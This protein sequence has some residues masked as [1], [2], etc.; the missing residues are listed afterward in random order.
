MVLGGHGNVYQVLDYPVD[1][2]VPAT[3][4]LPILRSGGDHT[5]DLLFAMPVVYI[6]KLAI[7]PDQQTLRDLHLSQL[8]HMNLNS[9]LKTFNEAFLRQQTMAQLTI[10]NPL[11]SQLVKYP[12]DPVRE[13]GI[14]MVLEELMDVMVVR[15]SIIA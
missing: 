11:T 5:Q 13:E 1:T 7:Y 9:M 8:L 15:R 6:S 12:K 3:A 14:V 4:V 2:H 10:A